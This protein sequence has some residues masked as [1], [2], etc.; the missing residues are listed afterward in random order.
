MLIPVFDPDASGDSILV[1]AL[2]E[3][4]GDAKAG[5][6]ELDTVDE[7]DEDGVAVAVETEDVDELEVD[8]VELDG[9]AEDGEVDI[10]RFGLLTFCKL[11]FIELELLVGTAFGCFVVAL[12]CELAASELVA[13][14]FEGLLLLL[15][16]DE[17]LL[18][19]SLGSTDQLY[20]SLA[21]SIRKDVAVD[22]SF[23]V[24]LAELLVSANEAD[25]LL[26]WIV[27]TPL[28]L[29]MTLDSRSLVAVFFFL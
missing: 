17:F 6:G 22:C 3:T 7:D 10:D 19:G 15:L 27:L 11:M 25:E 28:P 9:D 29:L 1:G 4:F 21:G 12:I 18:L 24:S 20:G 13:F 14:F 26:L 5:D 23:D 2:L 16:L 8:L